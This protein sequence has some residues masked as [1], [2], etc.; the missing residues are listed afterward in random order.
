MHGQHALFRAPANAGERIWR[1]MDF[2]KLVSMLH[3]Q[4]LFFCRADKLSDPFEGSYTASTIRRFEERG[5]EI[6]REFEDNAHFVK[7]MRDGLAAISGVRRQAR[8]RTATNCWHRNERDSAA[9]WSLYLKSDEGI[10]VA[11]TYARLCDSVRES[12]SQVLIG[13]VEYIDYETESFPHFGNLFSPY[14]HKRKSFEHEKELRAVVQADST[15]HGRA[16]EP[17]NEGGVSIRV[18]LDALIEAVY[19]APSAPAWFADVVAATIARFGRTF[20]VVQS[21]LSKEPLF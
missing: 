10:A 19:I 11:S 4:S 7:N 9:M 15:A 18:D 13:V 1:Y 12:E 2:T 17:W 8:E 20:T 6:A 16:V 21:D 5:E 14:L 3:T